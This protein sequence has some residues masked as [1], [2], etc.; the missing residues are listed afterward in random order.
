[1]RTHPA[2][3]LVI[4]CCAVAAAAACGDAPPAADPA[5]GPP[6]GPVAEA[7]PGILPL[8]EIMA[9]LERDLAAVAR[10]LWA[11]DMELIAAA[12][13][14]VAEHPR[15]PPEEM[16]AIQGR[17]GDEF[18]AFVNLDRRVHD[19]ALELAAEAVA[20]RPVPQLL[21]RYVQVQQ[22]CVACHV[23]YRD[24]VAAA[25]AGTERRTGPAPEG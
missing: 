4:A 19:D 3:A 14:R 24:R 23:A 9:G 20:A 21:D 22:G 8:K 2:R 5:A 10:G 7:T 1:M 17:L 15:V 6:A 18:P 16:Q 12:A 11:E 13:G 25:L